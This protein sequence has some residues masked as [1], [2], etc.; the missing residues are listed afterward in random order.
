MRHYILFRLLLAVLI[1]TP[2]FSDA[3]EVNEVF[4]GQDTFFVLP[5]DL[6]YT[7]FTANNT[8]IDENFPEGKYRQYLYEDKEE[9]ASEE[10]SPIAYYEFY[11][12][13]GLLEQTFTHRTN[14]GHLLTDG[15]YIQGKRH[16]FWQEYQLSAP[17]LRSKTFY[18]MG[19]NMQMFFYNEKGLLLRRDIH[20]HETDL[21]EKV[22]TT[23]FHPN[24]H[25][26]RQGV[27][28]VKASGKQLAQKEGQWRTWYGDG[29]PRALEYYENGDY[30]GKCQ[31]FRN[32]GQIDR[33]SIFRKGKLKKE[34]E[35]QYP[36]EE[37]QESILA[38]YK[39][40][41]GK[42]RRSVEL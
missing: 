4:E 12:R 40:K 8:R 42:V 27:T 36:D 29:S 18:E 25:P 24:G 28:I 11:L 32:D 9:N 26:A 2:T 38:L 20:F 22:I 23:W 17:L 10:A 1:G 13:D 35:Y 30:T 3:Q 7:A 39:D 31:Y 41:N 14:S 33:I 15:E 6:H 37:S 5:V 16:G 19:I 34:I 21:T